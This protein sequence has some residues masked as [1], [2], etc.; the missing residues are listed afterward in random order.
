MATLYKANGE[1]ETVSP[2][3]K[4]KFDVIELQE[5]VKG[6]FELLPATCPHGDK[7]YLVMNEEGKIRDL[8]VNH[9]ASALYDLF[10]DATGIGWILG[11][12]L[13]ALDSEIRGNYN[14]S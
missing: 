1:T 7:M 5:Y 3:S 11:D 4:K 14:E 9:R 2:V 13:L 6:P 8:P 12:V 10:G